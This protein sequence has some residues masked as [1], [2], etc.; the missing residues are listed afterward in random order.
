MLIY[1]FQKG[2]ME[3]VAMP[4]WLEDA[5]YILGAMALGGLGGGS[6]GAAFDLLLGSKEP[7]LTLALGT[8]GGNLGVAASVIG[9]LRRALRRELAKDKEKAE[10]DEDE[11]ESTE[12]LRATRSV[13]KLEKSAMPLWLQDILSI[14][15]G[16]A[17]GGVGGGATGAVLDLLLG[18]RAP[19]LTALLGGLGGGAGYT[20][21]FTSAL[22]REVRRA[23]REAREKNKEKTE[24]SKVD[25]STSQKTDEDEDEDEEAEISL[26]GVADELKKI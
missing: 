2:Q 19:I 10:K 14:L 22:R 24:N 8:A 17:L 21:G 16:T 23:L 26:K 13:D 6:A 12:K 7:L 4:A 11:T 5:L 3:K 1:D 15:G 25:R 9:S 18:S 20:T